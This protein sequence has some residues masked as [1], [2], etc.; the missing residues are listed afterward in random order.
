VFAVWVHDLKPYLFKINDAIALRYYGLAYL[1]GFVAAFLLLRFLARR[2]LYVLAEQQIGDFVALAALFGVFV[3]GRLGYILFYFLPEEGLHA[4]LED[5]LVVVRVWNGGMAS[6]GGVFGLMLFLWFYARR[7]RVS[8]TGLGDGICLGS[9]IGLLCGRLANFINGELYGRVTGGPL[10]IKFP[11]S[12]LDEPLAVREAALRAVGAAEPSLGGE[13]TID[14]IAEAVRVNPAVKQALEPFLSARH[15][16]QLYEAALE[17]AALF[18][19]LMW[20]RLRWPR[21]PHGVITGLFFALYAVFRIF[22]EQFREPDSPLV[23]PLTKGQFLSL[24]MLVVGAAFLVHG[25][26]DGRARAAP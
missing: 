4:L 20:V 19:I 10:G 13:P 23:G 26:R 3:G 22:V 1:I 24:F 14:M 17:G 2:G 12:L 7:H 9:T 16:S 11:Q 21:L 25:A 18:G 8:W 6:H 15:P 5:P